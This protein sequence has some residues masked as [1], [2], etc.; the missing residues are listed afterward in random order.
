[1]ALGRQARF[2]YTFPALGMVIPFVVPTD[3]SGWSWAGIETWCV[4]PLVAVFPLVILWKRWDLE[5]TLKSYLSLDKLMR[6]PL[7]KEIMGHPFSTKLLGAFMSG[8]DISE[9]RQRFYREGYPSDDED[10][11]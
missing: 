6:E 2:F 4:L 7:A 3:D 11:Q 10:E 5:R 1:V 9:E 8:E